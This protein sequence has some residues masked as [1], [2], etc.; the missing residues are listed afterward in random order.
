MLRAV[1]MGIVAAIDRDQVLLDTL[2]G[3]MTSL[4]LKKKPH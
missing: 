4:F 3:A 1:G 2:S